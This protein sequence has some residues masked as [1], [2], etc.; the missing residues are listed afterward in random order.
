MNLN[1]ISGDWHR[2][3][4]KRK[5]AELPVVSLEAFEERKNAHEKE[6]RIAENPEKPEIETP[7]SG[8]SQKFD[9]QANSELRF[10]LLFV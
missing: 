9:F 4:L 7:S 5:V 1:C 10:F 6:A 8:F 2:Y 3:N